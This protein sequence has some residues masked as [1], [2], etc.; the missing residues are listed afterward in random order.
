M[1]KGGGKIYSDG[2]KSNN[3]IYVFIRMGVIK[4]IFSREIR[5]GI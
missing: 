4:N 1:N 5:K 3:I 2:L